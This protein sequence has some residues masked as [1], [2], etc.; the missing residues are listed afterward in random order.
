M[1]WRFALVALLLV[2]CSVLSYFIEGVCR[3]ARTNSTSASPGNA[4]RGT[5]PKET[6]AAKGTRSNDV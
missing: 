5:A 3:R 6:G 4:G 1:L 2:V